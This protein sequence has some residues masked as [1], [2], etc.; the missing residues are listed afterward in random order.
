MVFIISKR[1][2]Q[3]TISTLFILIILLIL[4]IFINPIGVCESIK[5][6]SSTE[7]VNVITSYNVNK[8]KHVLLIIDKLDNFSIQQIY[9]SSNNI[10]KLNKQLSSLDNINYLIYN[11]IIDY[12]FS[13][14]VEEIYIKL[15]SSY[16]YSSDL[17]SSIVYNR[18]FV[19]NEHIK[20]YNNQRILLFKLKKE[21]YNSYITCGIDS[22][23]YKEKL[24]K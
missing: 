7:F 9:L 17:K 16:F 22:S 10:I 21:L 6:I 1:Y 24:T 11:D 15:I 19:L 3:Y 5:N 14:K 2:F 4:I 12:V 18:Y 13:R 23:L 8:L 20:L